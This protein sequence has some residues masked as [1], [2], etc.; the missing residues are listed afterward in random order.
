[1][2]IPIRL[3]DLIEIDFK[4]RTPVTTNTRRRRTTWHVGSKEQKQT[5]HTLRP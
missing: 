5:L 4:L 3:A 1:M 2:P